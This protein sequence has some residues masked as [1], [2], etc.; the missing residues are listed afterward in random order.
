M[1]LRC[2][3]GTAFLLALAA[4]VSARGA[5]SLSVAAAANLTYAL[6]AL[7]AAYEAAS[8]GSQVTATL[9]SSGNLVAQI[10]NGAPFDV[11]LSADLDFARALVKS[12]NAG[13]GGVTPFAVGRLVLWTPRPGVDLSSV[14]S[15]V[16]SPSVRTL[17]VA[18]ADTAPY[19]RASRQAL[20]RLGLWPDAQPKLVT[21]ENIAQAAQFVDTGNADAGFVAMSAV[22]APSVRGRGRWIEVPA[23]L[24][25][26]LVQG[27]VVTAHGA[28]NPESA[29]YIAFLHSAEA[30]RIL[31]GL[32]YGLP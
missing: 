30:A 23:G 5:G 1:R 17:A 15:A 24:Y 4:A 3:R 32:G 13:P 18:N 8:P 29:R 20:Q 14:A 19:G 28:Q 7:D 9:G 10:R 26:P 12:G 16:R 6:K 22:L 2:L 21:A 31:G 11:F 27:A 25:D